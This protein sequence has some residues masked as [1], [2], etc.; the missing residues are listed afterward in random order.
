MPSIQAK[1]ILPEE[2]YAGEF[3]LWMSLQFSNF[4]YLLSKRKWTQMQLMNALL[5]FL[6]CTVALFFFQEPCYHSEVFHAPTD[7]LG[8]S[9]EAPLNTSYPS[10]TIERVN[11]QPVHRRQQQL[12]LQLTI[13][14]W[15]M[16]LRDTQ[17]EVPSQRQPIPH[18]ILSG[19]LH[20]FSKSCSVK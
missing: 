11:I 16:G 20:R 1:S 4:I 3:F 10:L 7:L 13:P 17:P 2:W 14:I 5:Y 8:L 18:K 12:S 19:T 15:N 6:P 9:W